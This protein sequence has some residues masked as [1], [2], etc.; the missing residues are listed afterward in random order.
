MISVNIMQ[1][2]LPRKNGGAAFYFQQV[3]IIVADVAALTAIMTA[4]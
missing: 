1:A 4:I 2:A 3:E